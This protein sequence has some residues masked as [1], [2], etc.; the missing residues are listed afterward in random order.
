MNQLVKF[1]RTMGLFH[2]VQALI[3]LALALFLVRDLAEFEPVIVARFMDLTDTGELIANS[4]DLFTLPFAIATTTFLFVSAFFHGLIVFKKEAYLSGIKKGYNRF[5][6]IEYAISSSILIT[7]LAILF[8]VRDVQSILLIF[9][10]NGVMNLMG[11][12]M[13]M[14][15]Q[16]TTNPSFR[17]YIIGWIIG[18]APWVVILMYLFYSPNLDMVPWY[19]WAGIIAYFLFFNSFAFNMLLQYKKI[20]PWKDYVFG[21]RMYIW[22][23]LIA[24]STIAWIVYA[25]ALQAADVVN[26]LF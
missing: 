4:K 25:G 21:E 10:A 14:Q 24:K 19:G 22:L 13:E 15:N 20:G 16:N 7:L 6:W 1:N 12:D 26:E 2:F 9:V 17:P 8:G 5:R 23:S 18:L 11:L 3:M